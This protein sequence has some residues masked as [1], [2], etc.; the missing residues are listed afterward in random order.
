MTLQGKDFSLILL[1]YYEEDRVRRD[2]VSIYVISLADACFN[3]YF[4]WYS[5]REL[6]ETSQIAL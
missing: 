4:G 2:R 5:L 1:K 3:N 6:R